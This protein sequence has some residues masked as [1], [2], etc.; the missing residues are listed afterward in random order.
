MNGLHLRE[1]LTRVDRDL[2]IRVQS[3]IQGGL[4]L[5]IPPLKMDMMA[6]IDP[7]R[8]AFLRRNPSAAWVAFRGNRPVGR[9]MAIHNLDALA[10][11]QDGVGHFGF[12]E[13]ENDAEVVAALVNRAADWLRARG[14][15][16]MRGPF[17]PSINHETGL[18][19]DGF[20]SPP[21][22]LMNYAPAYYGPALEAAGFSQEMDIFSFTT[23]TTPEGQPPAVRTLFERLRSTPGLSIRLLD[24]KRYREDISTLVEVYNDGWSGNWGS[25][26]MSGA[27]AQEL[28]DMLRPLIRP[29]W[30]MFADYKG[31]T[32]GV[33]LQ[34]PDLNEAIRDFGGRLLPFNWA[35]LLRRMRKP[36][37][38]NSRMLMLG[39]RQAFQGRTIGPIAG[40]LLI[41]AALRAA[42]ENG[43]TSGEIG[44]VLE[45]NKAI[46]SI[47]N[48][49]SVTGR[50]TYRIYGMAI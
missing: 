6:A 25:V 28:G 27:E 12:I 5:A 29:E 20:D 1:V 34:M 31:Q 30:L 41:D 26:P 35:R 23:S 22:Y 49:F 42:N 15:A 2:F 37:V 13:F 3:I 32:V 39:V 38:K 16:A 47:V 45:T 14:L 18:L 50:K 8:S 19:V 40:M 4:P 9:I 21:A 24:P 10:K 33:A 17:S 48:K 7:D 11:H 46:L 43:I 44:W 36:T